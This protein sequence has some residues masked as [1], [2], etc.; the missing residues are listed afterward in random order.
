MISNIHSIW[1]FIQRSTPAIHSIKLFN[2]IFILNSIQKFIQNPGKSHSKFYQGLRIGKNAKCPLNR[3]WISGFNEVKC[4]ENIKLGKI[5]PQKWR[6]HKE[7]VVSMFTLED[8]TWATDIA[9][10][11]L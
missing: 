10:Q 3:P 7:T 2:S 9:D 1:L 4:V 5:V 6:F 11:F 8:F